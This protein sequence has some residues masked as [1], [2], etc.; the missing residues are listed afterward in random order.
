[1]EDE[2]AVLEFAARVLADQGYTV[3]RA[4]RAADALG[5]CQT[6]GPI[7]LVVTDVIMPGGMSG[8]DL[9]RELSRTSPR[10]PVL[11]MSGYAAESMKDRGPTEKPFRL[12]EKPFTSTALARSVREMLDAA[13]GEAGL[14]EASKSP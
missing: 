5:I 7:H 11:M 13:K 4:T 10:T 2:P 12:L 3:L 14:P 9:A 8:R 1:V 6:D